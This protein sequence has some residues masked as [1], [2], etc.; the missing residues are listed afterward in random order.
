MPFDV[1]LRC[2]KDDNV[3]QIKFNEDGVWHNEDGVWHNW[4]QHYR[5]KL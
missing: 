4:K 3:P 2:G 1:A 5:V